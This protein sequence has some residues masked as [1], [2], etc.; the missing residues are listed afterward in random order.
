MMK[1]R[2]PEDRRPAPTF[3]MACL[4]AG[5]AAGAAEDA[6]AVVGAFVSG[7]YTHRLGKHMFL[8]P[9]TW[10]ETNTGIS[11]EESSGGFDIQIQMGAAFWTAQTDRFPLCCQLRDGA[12]G[13][14]RRR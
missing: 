1:K 7:G 8:S 14:S 11:R 3:G 12:P 5:L 4:L 10:L 9:D 13:R 2:H 6:A